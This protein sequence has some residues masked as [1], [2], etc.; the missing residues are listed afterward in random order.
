MLKELGGIMLIYG[1]LIQ[2]GGMWFVQDKLDFTTG[3]WIGI[4]LAF[5]LLWHM[6]R[7]IQNAVELDEE[8]AIH[9]MRGGTSIRTVAILAIVVIVYYLSLGN[10]LMVFVGALGLKVAAYLQPFVHERFAK[11]NMKK[12]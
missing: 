11:E 10:V 3:L 8:G 9:R 5:F 12:N 7:S 2:A 6:N 4:A 1:G